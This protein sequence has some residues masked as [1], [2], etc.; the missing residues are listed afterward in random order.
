MTH[1]ATIVGID[2]AKDWLDV[3]VLPSQQRLRVANDAAGWR[4]IRA[5]CR[6]GTI[7]GLEASGGYERGVLRALLAKGI[8]VRRITPYRLRR[9]A[10]AMGIK[11]KTDRLDAE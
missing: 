7:V 10:Q 2:V 5:L 9:Y 1:A 11:A 6:P 3:C 8:E 4:Q